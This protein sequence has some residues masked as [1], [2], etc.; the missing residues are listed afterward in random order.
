MLLN[1]V[2]KHFHGVAF[3]S[4]LVTVRYST[5][6]KKYIYIYA[7]LVSMEDIT[8]TFSHISNYIFRYRNAKKNLICDLDLFSCDLLLSI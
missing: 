5:C 4:I 8:K 3:H 1:S 2:W 7:A 6:K